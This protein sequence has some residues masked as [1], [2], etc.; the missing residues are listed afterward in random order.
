MTPLRKKMVEDLKI[1]NYSEDTVRSYVH[2]VAQLAVFFKRS[3][4]ALQPEQIRTYLVHLVTVKKPSWSWYN[5]QVCGIRFFYRVTLARDWVIAHVPYGRRP[6]RIPVILSRDEVTRFFE[7]IDEPMFRVL[8]MTIYAAGLRVSE[9]L[10]LRPT[11][12]DSERMLILVRE[13]KGR[14]QRLA[15]LSRTLLDDLREYYRAYRP[16]THLFFGRTPEV[17]VAERTLRAACQRARLA[18]GIRRTF[19]IHDLRSSFAT[20]LL[21]AGVDIRTIQVILGHADLG[22]TERYVRVRENLISATQSPLDLL[23]FGGRPAPLPAK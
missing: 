10:A 9:A 19:T 12:I 3:P 21:E 8:L 18:A 6:T 13:G 5:V 22:T 1:R 17:P 7:A 16:Q 15:P 20:H 2:A 23:N 4:D 14:K 11:D